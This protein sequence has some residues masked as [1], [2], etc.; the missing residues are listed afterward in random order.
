MKRIQFS[1]P[2]NMN[3][4]LRFKL[5]F[6]IILVLAA[7][8]LLTWTGLAYFIYQTERT[9]AFGRQVEAADNAAQE[10]ASFLQRIE[11]NLNLL[12]LFTKNELVTNSSILSRVVSNDPALLEVVYLDRSGHILASASKGPSVLSA[13]LDIPK[14]E[15]F[16]Q[17]AMNEMYLSEIQIPGQSEPYLILAGPGSGGVIVVRL[18]MSVLRNVVSNIR[19]GKTG[20]IYI[21]D[22]F[23]TVIAHTNP[24]VVLANT[25]LNG[26]TEIESILKSA[27]Q[28]WQGMYTNFEGIAVLGVTAPIPNTPWIIVTELPRFEAFAFSQFAI[29]LLIVVF[30][31]SGFLLARFFT[32]QLSRIILQPL[33]EL[34]HAA[35]QIGDG[36]LDYRVVAPSNDEIR[37]VSQA[38]NS[39][40]AGLQEQGARLAAQTASLA[41]E[42]AE[43]KRAEENLQQ[44]NDELE[45]RVAERTD[46]L[47]R[48]NDELQQISSRYT[49][50]VE[51][52]PAIIYI[53]KIEDDPNSPYK[54][55]FVSPQIESIL[56]YSPE[57]WIETPDLWFRRI[58]PDDLE[59][60]IA[61][62]QRSFQNNLPIQTEYRIIARNGETR[63]IRDE[64]VIHKNK[65]GKPDYIQGVML[66]I[67]ERKQA[68]EQLA[69]DAFHD[70][71]TG[72][73]NRAL[74]IDRLE[75]ALKRY[76][77]RDDLHYAVLFMDL[78]RFK[79]VNDSMGHPAGDQ[80]LIQLAR[81]LNS[82]A[83]AADTVSRLGGDEFV[84]LLEDIRGPEDAIQ[85]ANRIQDEL[86]L[87]FILNQQIVFTSV[88]IG[89]V[90]GRPTYERAEDLLRDADIAMYRAKA[91]GKDRYV[92]YDESLRIETMASLEL[93]VDLRLALEREE[94]LL[95]Y[96]P[97]LSLQTGQV[98]GFEAL[99]RWQHP[100]RGLLFPGD[101]MFQA[102]ESGLT[103]PLGWWVFRQACRQ[104]REWQSGFGTRPLTMNVNISARQF[105]ATELVETL[106]DI[107]NETGITPENLKID[108][109]EQI[110]LEMRE[111]ALSTLDRL[112]DLGVQ[113]EIDDFGSGYAR[114]N[115][116]HRFP[117]SFIKIGYSFISR[118]PGNQNTSNMVRSII[119]FA[120]QLGMHTV[121]EGIET[122]EQMECLRS[123]EC[124]YGQGFLIS[125][126]LNP[127]E[128]ADLLLSQEPK[129][130]LDYP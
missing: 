114:L 113:I 14:T 10:V 49:T 28:R 94:F 110:I 27:N 84:I 129:H 34:Y 75:S 19:F 112:R 99:I 102:E 105:L 123:L 80:L 55:V 83:R 95:F 18:Q 78:D 61:E 71:L 77:R 46:A 68:E 7:V 106:S 11:S 1:V 79:V 101:F 22:P 8:M 117:V 60:L 82:T 64:G 126:P 29:I 16:R 5:V 25:H 89:I 33:E 13:L 73:P 104:L 9:S 37:Q 3:K 45:Q 92:I 96:Q 67:T 128:A 100:R 24:Q 56:G 109:K 122:T 121:A 116:L 52:I 88:S 74:F 115:E 108:I 72:L 70:S 81:R 12:D 17:A 4:S 50:L 119:L 125:K 43:R 51:Q 58:F 35:R 97:V 36:N 85:V 44:L 30:L 118:L 54:T 39:M 63:W 32:W 47:S 21:I 65:D 2:G 31:F 38:F 66:D 41:A 59:R 20:R 48:I 76:H 40:A 93:E 57:E 90:F 23:G 26:R 62:D 111:T 103:I 6:L 15:W 86:K 127:Q 53:S 87:P 42:V 107:L 130:P 69:Y 124:Q 98:T 120:R 91:L